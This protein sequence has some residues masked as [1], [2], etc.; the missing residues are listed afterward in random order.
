MDAGGVDPALEK[1]QKHESDMT[2]KKIQILLV[3]YQITRKYKLFSRPNRNE[4]IDRI[5][6]E[7]G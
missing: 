3:Q 5:T 1:D 6:K 7:L 2:G 4:T